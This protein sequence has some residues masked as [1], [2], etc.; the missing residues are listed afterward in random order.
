MNDDIADPGNRA[1]LFTRGNDVTPLS[2]LVLPTGQVGDEG[3]FMLTLPDP[4]IS[5]QNG[6]LFTTHELVTATGEASDENNLDKVDAVVPLGDADIARLEGRIVCGLVFDSDVS[7]TNHDPPS[8]S[9]KG[10]TLGLT[11]FRVTAVNPNPAGPDNLLMITVDLL[12]SADV[13][14]VCAGASGAPGPPSES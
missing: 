6:A 8:A 7:V 5:L 14:G 3:L 9:L 1:P 13:Q 12:P 10:A 4:Q 2:G 11:A